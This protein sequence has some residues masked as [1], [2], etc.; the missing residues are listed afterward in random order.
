MKRVSKAIIGLSVLWAAGA[1]APALAD[2]IPIELYDRMRDAVQQ[3]DYEGR[4]VYQVGDQLDAMYVVHR[5]QNGRRLERLVALDGA[6]KQVIRGAMAVACLDS[7]ERKI[8]V[9]GADS[10]LGQTP[11]VG[12]EELSR[13]Y[14]F[15]MGGE[16]RVAG[17]QARE[18]LIR[19]RDDLR[20]G[21]RIAL[22]RETDLPLH[23]I[24][25]DE[26]ERVRSQTLFVDL[27]TGSQVTPIE[28]DLSALQKTEMPAIDWLDAKT[29]G[30][31]SATE[32]SLQRLPPGFR[33]IDLRSPQPD[34]RHL[35]L[36]D[37]IASVSLYVEPLDEQPLEGYS[38]AGSTEIYATRRHNLQVIVVGEVPRKTL[39]LIAAA[40]E[41]P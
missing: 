18:L 2:E 4:F 32:I 1:A 38:S 40:L 12:T 25:L 10:K 21:Y 17:R 8:S 39:G 26:A 7:Q 22:D 16:Y 14:R 41:L 3:V 20:F 23:S 15:E 5:M 13:F 36:T 11:V 9:V 6:P 27:K 37:G 19:P 28:R 24:M 33:L 29:E 31:A 35:L 30:A 34:V